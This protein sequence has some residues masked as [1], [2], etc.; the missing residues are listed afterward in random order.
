M[1]VGYILYIVLQFQAWTNIMSNIFGADWIMYLGVTTTSSFMT[2]HMKWAPRR[3]TVGWVGRVSWTLWGRQTRWRIMVNGF[4]RR[5]LSSSSLNSAL[6]F[7][8]VNSV[9]HASVF[10]DPRG[11]SG[12]NNSVISFTSPAMWAQLFKLLTL[13]VLLKTQKNDSFELCVSDDAS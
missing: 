3:V 4:V 6:Y 8:N 5:L 12:R 13:M 7:K 2:D 10:D 1:R 9:K 11:L